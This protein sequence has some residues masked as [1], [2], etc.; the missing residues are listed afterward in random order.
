MARSARRGRELLSGATVTMCD[1]RVERRDMGNEKI[2]GGGVGR[3]RAIQC[4]GSVFGVRPHGPRRRAAAPARA[5]AK[6]LVFAIL[7][8]TPARRGR[9]RLVLR[10]VGFEARACVVCEILRRRGARLADKKGV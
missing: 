2:C 4:L 5:Q 1:F 3:R 10:E 9:P 6:K 7:G 8:F